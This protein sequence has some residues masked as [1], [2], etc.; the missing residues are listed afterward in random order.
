MCSHLAKFNLHI[1]CLPHPFLWFGGSV[2]GR[3]AGLVG[4]QVRAVKR[5]AIG[6][7]VKWVIGPVGLR[8]GVFVCTGVGGRGGVL[9]WV[10]GLISCW[11]LIANL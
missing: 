8:V 4:V 10:A 9:V 5:M 7:L 6:R 2:R 11:C 1:I 3:A